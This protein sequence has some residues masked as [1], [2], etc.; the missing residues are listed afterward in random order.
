MAIG[1]FQVKVATTGINREKF[2]G[3]LGHLIA[4]LSSSSSTTTAKIAADKIDWG[5]DHPDFGKATAVTHVAAEIAKSMSIPLKEAMEAL[6]HASAIVS[7]QA[8][9]MS[10]LGAAPLARV[11]IDYDEY[12]LLQRVAHMAGQMLGPMRDANL[13]DTEYSRFSA[14]RNA[15]VALQIY[16]DP[17]AITR[18]LPDDEVVND[19]ID[20]R[21]DLG[22]QASA[23]PTP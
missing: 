12:G 6:E 7:R 23:L 10:I 13:N 3:S 16:E 9:Q 5:A 17:K 21:D 18:P 22:E 19:L 2:N 8:G 15:L 4:D 11:E 1:E 20:L 14:L